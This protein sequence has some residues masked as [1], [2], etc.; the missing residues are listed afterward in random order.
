M[1]A[2]ALVLIA[3]LAACAPE[4]DRSAEV[5]ALIHK[6]AEERLESFRRIKMERCR[7]SILEEATRVVDSLLIVE[8]RLEKDSSGRPVKPVRP[9]RPDIRQLQ[10]SSPV[11]PLLS[12]EDTLPPQDSLQHFFQCSA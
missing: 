5:E 11:K 12:E 1:A 3:I 6:N 7:E 8:A 2:S 4:R 9:P 10:D